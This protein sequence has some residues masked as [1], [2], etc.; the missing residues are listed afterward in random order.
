MRSFLRFCHH[1]GYLEHDLAEA[2]P[3]I[4]RYKLSDVPRGVSDEDAQKT[5]QGIDRTTPVGRRDFAMIQLLHSYGVRGGQLRA[6]RVDDI[7][8]R[9]NRIRFPASKGGKEVIEPLTEE[10]GESL[11]EYLRYGR[12]QAPHLEVFLTVHPPYRPLSTCR[13]STMVAE[14][15][16]NAAVSR[17][18]GS[19]AFRH[20]FATRMLQHGQT[21]KTIADLLGHRNINTTFIY[22][23]VDIETLRQ[24]PLDWPEVSP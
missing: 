10:V 3:P 8:W 21:I 18:K 7:R 22:T 2:I 11:L 15:M 14:R 16:R 1:K 24:L 17:P 9:E 4:R 6:L 12:P 13:V 23:K 19:H 5:L 20:G